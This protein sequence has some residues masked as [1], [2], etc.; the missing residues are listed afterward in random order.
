MLKIHATSILLV[1]FFI[2]GLNVNAYAQKI[3][4]Y[5]EDPSVGMIL[6]IR[7]G[8]DGKVHVKHVYDI[9]H[10]TGS[11]VNDGYNQIAWENFTDG[12][13]SVAIKKNK[14]LIHSFTDQMPQSFERI[15]TLSAACKQAAPSTDA[16]KNYD[17]ITSYFNEYYPDITIRLRENKALTPHSSFNDVVKKHRARLTPTSNQAELYSAVAE[18]LGT[19]EDGHINLF[20]GGNDHTGPALDVRPHSR[21]DLNCFNQQLES[22]YHE[23]YGSTAFAYRQYQS[24]KQWQ[25]LVDAHYIRHPK[26]ELFYV[27]NGR[28]PVITYGLLA[29]NSRIGYFRMTQELLSEG[30]VSDKKEMREMI[31]A[32]KHAMQYLAVRHVKSIVIDLRNNEGGNDYYSFYIARFFISKPT[33]GYQYARRYR[34]QW[35]NKTRVILKPIQDSEWA[36]ALKNVHLYVLTSPLTYSSGE[37]L[38]AIL[39]SLPQSTLVG[40]PTFGIFSEQATRQMPNGWIFK[41]PLGHYEFAN[42]ADYI[43]TGVTP[44]VPVACEQNFLSQKNLN[45]HRDV[46]LDKVLT[47]Y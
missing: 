16:I 18:V 10:N 42:N 2:L 30:D 13:A 44:T 27:D 40:Y 31:H 23:H 46:V 26:R 43:R 35:T 17:F 47:L 36:N 8:G 3:D 11:C 28:A 25:N 22:E 45:Q 6:D 41:I 20:R 1:S 4:G 39:K 33:L 9:N 37:N 12:V 29:Q 21:P 24:I 7:T 32:I 19:L 38:S 15:K 34:H 14:L 5:W